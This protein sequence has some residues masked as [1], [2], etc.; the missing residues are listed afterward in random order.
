[1]ISDAARLNR[2]S[3]LKTTSH[4]VFLAVPVDP[5]RPGANQL[6]ARLDN[7]NGREINRARLKGRLSE[8]DPSL[9]CQTSHSEDAPQVAGLEKFG[10]GQR[11][12]SSGQKNAFSSNAFESAR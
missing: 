7:A 12:G 9:R 3:L 10:D 8:K 11:G 1:M 5:K 4:D 6:T 2:P